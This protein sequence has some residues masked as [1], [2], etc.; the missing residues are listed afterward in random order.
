MKISIFGLGYVGSVT[1]ACLSEKGHDIVGVDVNA[2]K[3]AL[4]NSGDAPIVEPEL[5][6]LLQA[7]R[8]DGRLRATTDSTE[9]VMAT[10]ASIV[11]VGTPSLDSGGLDLRYVREVCRQ[12]ADALTKKTAAIFC[13]FEALCCPAAP[14]V[15]PG[16]ISSRISTRAG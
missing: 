13:F 8:A 5:G 15:S 6:R 4:I 10:D 3:V 1:G 7:A 12:L 9:A 11:C 14:A 16:R 2:D